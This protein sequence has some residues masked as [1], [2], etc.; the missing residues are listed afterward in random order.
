MAIQRPNLDKFKRANP[1]PNHKQSKQKSD[2][3]TDVGGGDMIMELGKAF[4]PKL[5]K[6][7]KY[8]IGAA[9]FFL[10]WG[11]FNFNYCMIKWI[12]WGYFFAIVLILQVLQFDDQFK[13]SDKI[14]KQFKTKKQ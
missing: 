6:K 3:K 11:V 4:L 10:A 1:L 2:N 13:I 7:F 9:I 12:E 14:L 5:P 8:A